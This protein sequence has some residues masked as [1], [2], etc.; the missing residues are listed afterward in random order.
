MTTTIAEQFGARLARIAEAVEAI[1]AEAANLAWR[2]GGWTLKQTLGHLMDSAANNRQRFVRAAI[3][4][5][6]EGPSY[7]QEGW[8]RMHGYIDLPWETLKKWWRTE[9]DIL[10][11]VVAHIPE[12]RMD[13][14]CRVGGNAP[15]TLAYL[16]DDYVAHHEHHLAQMQC[17]RQ[18]T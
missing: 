15:V 4:G 13:A 17:W 1:P 14:T 9:T 7:D 6:Y 16:I 3:D 11:A 2:P 12:D 8:V 18:S 5:S 10:V